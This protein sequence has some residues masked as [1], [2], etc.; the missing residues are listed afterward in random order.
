MPSVPEKFAKVTPE[1]IQAWGKQGLSETVIFDMLGLSSVS[2]RVIK[3]TDKWNTNYKM[4]LALREQELAEKISQSN[5]VG[6]I[7]EV[8]RTMSIS[9]TKVVDESAEFI[10]DAPDW[11]R[12]K[13]NKGKKGKRAKAHNQRDSV[14]PE[15]PADIS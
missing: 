10:I 6:L 11:M 15:V 9:Q 12:P 4:G 5:D 14:Q 3:A 1:E 2:R 7:R 13:I 8:Y